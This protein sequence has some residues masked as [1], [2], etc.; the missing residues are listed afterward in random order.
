MK[1]MMTALLGICMATG[2]PALAQLTPASVTANTDTPYTGRITAEMYDPQGNRLVSRYGKAEIKVTSPE[3]GRIRLEASGVPEGVE[4]LTLKSTLAAGP[5]GGW[6][7][8]DEAL[9][10]R[11]SPDGEISG[12]GLRGDEK[13]TFSGRVTDE[14]LQLSVKTTLLESAGAGA[15][16]GTYSLMEFTARR[17]VE[18]PGGDGI[19]EHTTLETRV[20]PN[21]F[22]GGMTTVMVPVC[23]D[24]E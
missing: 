12:G 6:R 22:G 1:R 23:V 4:K 17:S 24:E 15:P 9:P 11:I 19:C 8:V 2:A 14:S 3:E 10:M 20:S 16:A 21:T 18:S 7:D 5:D 13:V